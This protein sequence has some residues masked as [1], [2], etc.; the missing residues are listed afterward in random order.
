MKSKVGVAIAVHNSRDQTKN[1]LDSLLRSDYCNLHI[2]VVDDGSSDGTWEMLKRDYPSVIVLRGDGNL[3]WTRANN[4]AIKHCIT[5]G[6]DYIALLN[7]DVL[8]EPET[9]HILC[10]HSRA[11][12][13]AIVSPI[14]LDRDQPNRIWEAGHDWEPLFKWFPLFWIS[15][16]KYKH[17][18]AIAK[19]PKEPYPTVSV[20]GRGGLIPRKAFETLGLF[21]E[22]HLPHYGADMDMALRAW[23]AKYPMYIVPKAKAYLDT[24]HTSKKVPTTFRDAWISYINY[25]ISRKYGEALRALYY[26]NVNNMPLRIAVPNYVFLLILNSFRRS[27]EHTSELQSH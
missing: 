21:D 22:K 12:S 4:W 14:V 20:V 10:E 26:V 9:L 18:T 8:V 16:Y 5:H 6:C 3:W 23:R 7:P 13:D 15:K 27:E 1:C 24:N 25:L 11:L 17:G 19:L 2:V